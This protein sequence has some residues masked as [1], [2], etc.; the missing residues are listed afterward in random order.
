M[1][2]RLLLADDSITVQRV[3]EL[4]FSREDVEVVCVSDGEAAIAWM[5]RARPDV[6]L[7]DVGMSRGNGYEVAAFMRS[8]P[9][10][11]DVPVLLLAGAFEPL[12]TARAEQVGYDGV[13]VKPFEPQHVIARVLELLHR[14]RERA[15]EAPKEAALPAIEPAPIASEPVPPVGPFAEAPGTGSTEL[16]AYFE[17]LDAQFESL[18]QASHVPDAPSAGEAVAGE[19][20]PVLQADSPA[21]LLEMTRPLQAEDESE[22]RWTLSA[23]STEPRPEP[24]LSEVSAMLAAALDTA[25]PLRAVPD[26]PAPADRPPV[27]E[28][29]VADGPVAAAAPAAGP[30]DEAFNRPV[31]APAPA[32]A[33]YAPVAGPTHANGRHVLADAFAAL[34]AVEQGEAGATA[35]DLG[36]ALWA[37]VM[38][39]AFVDEVTRRVLERLAPDAAREVV[40]RVVSDVAERLVREEVGRARERGGQLH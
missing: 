34:L 9:E 18:A 23:P 25:P 33:A 32:P 40:V 28:I 37:P 14:P 29:P 7:A 19:G 12:D 30:P 17:Q 1:S 35:P 26:L 36:V 10:L 39:N 31:A 38:T 2:Y 6:V 5:G 21:E 11:R 8:R 15:L 24:T 20:E 4:T 16:D 22:P 27:R 3:I 13:L